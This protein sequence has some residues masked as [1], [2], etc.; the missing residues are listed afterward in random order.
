MN[1]RKLLAFLVGVFAVLAVAALIF[2]FSSQDGQ[3]SSKTSDEVVRVIVKSFVR[4]YDALPPVRQRAIWQKISLYVRKDAH[5]LEYTALGLFLRLL[6][7]SLC[8]RFPWLSAC[9]CGA[10]YAATD[11]FH[12]TF[13]NARGGMWQD[14]LLDSAGVLFGCAMALVL[15]PLIAMIWLKRKAR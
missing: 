10:L 9:L 6:A 7:S 14:V 15:A 8:L 5:F 2:Y 12:Q 1:R 3:T 4:D 13:V 11:E